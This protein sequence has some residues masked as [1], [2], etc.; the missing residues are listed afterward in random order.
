MQRGSD[1]GRQLQQ[2]LVSTRKAKG[3]SQRTLAEKARGSAQT[4]QNIETG[5]TSPSVAT[6]ERLAVALQVPI[7]SVLAEDGRGAYPGWSVLQ[8]AEQ[9]L[10]TAAVDFFAAQRQEGRTA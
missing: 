8:V 10:V 1:V 3:W 4:V 6:V 2:A 5:G 7:A 9:A